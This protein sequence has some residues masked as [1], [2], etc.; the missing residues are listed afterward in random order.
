[1]S[2]MLFVRGLTPRYG[3]GFAR[4]KGSLSFVDWGAS[5]FDPCALA[6]EDILSLYLNLS[7]LVSRMQTLAPH[8]NRP[9]AR[10]G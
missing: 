7:D 6:F 1:M 4:I 5:A 10:I 3:R 9:A 2:Q 8:L